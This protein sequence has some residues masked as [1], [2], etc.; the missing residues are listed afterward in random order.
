[1]LIVAGH[2][3]VDPAS[4][5]AYLTRCIPIVEQARRTAGCLDF[6]LGPDLV[7]PSRINVFERWESRAT[8][9]RF[10]GDGPDDDQ[11]G[12]TRFADVTEYD[13]PE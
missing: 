10:R 2:L 7:D 11:Q 4:R 13:V 12:A 8:L 1:M 3:V 9:E 6:S 5:D